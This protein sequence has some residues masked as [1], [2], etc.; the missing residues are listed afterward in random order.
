MVFDGSVGVE[1][2]VELVV[3]AELES[4]PRQSV[5]SF[6]RA[7]MSFGQIGCV[8]GDLVGDHTDLHIVA[9]GKSQMLF[10]GHVAEHRSTGLCDHRRADRRGDVV[11]CGGDVGGERAQRVE[12]CLLAQLFLEADVLD[13][14]VHGD[15]PGTLDHHLHAMGFRDLG[16]FAQRAQFGEL[17]GI[18]GVGDRARSQ[19]VS[20][21]ERDVVAGEDLAQLFEVGVEE[22]LL[23]MGQTPG[24][25]DGPAA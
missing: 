25:H 19:T 18:V 10:R 2:E 3:P 6:L 14:L 8:R 23:M 20:E 1:G 17:S 16:E 21:G 24:G 5:V 22:R 15:V 11:V 13:D 7:R 12:R 4:C 9:I